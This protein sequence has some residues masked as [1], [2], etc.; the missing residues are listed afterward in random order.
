MALSGK[1]RDSA[2]GLR[3]S[4]DLLDE[5][6]GNGLAWAAPGGE[7]IHHDDIVLLEGGVELGLAV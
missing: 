4:E 2:F 6:W 5:S 1:G 3:P 7:S